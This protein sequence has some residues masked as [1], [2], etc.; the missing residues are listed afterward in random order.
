MEKFLKLDVLVNTCVIAIIILLWYVLYERRP[1]CSINCIKA[2]RAIVAIICHPKAPVDSA[3]ASEVSKTIILHLH[4]Q[5]THIFIIHTH[6]YCIAQ[7]LV[8]EKF[9]KFGKL[10]FTTFKISAELPLF[11]EKYGTR[12]TCYSFSVFRFFPYHLQC[13]NTLP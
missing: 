11:N 1:N 6:V 4:F 13:R 2:A 9:S 10:N 5:Y 7:I 3:H 12:F 8:G